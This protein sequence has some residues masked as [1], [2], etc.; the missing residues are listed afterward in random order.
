[1]VITAM[2]NTSEEKL[3]QTIDLI[4]DFH[5]KY[6]PGAVIGAYM[7]HL[8]QEKLQPLSGKLNAIAESTVC[9]ADAIQIM[10]GCTIGNKYLWLLNY[11][12]YALC[13]YDRDTKEGIRV[14]VDYSKIDPVKTP[15]L[16][17]F[18]DGTRTYESIDRPTQQQMVNQE[19]SP[20]N[21]PFLDGKKFGLT[22]QVKVLYQILLS[23]MF[24][25]N[26]IK[27]SSNRHVVNVSPR[28][29]IMKLLLR[30]SVK[31][32]IIKIG[33]LLVFG[34]SH[35]II[36]MQDPLVLSQFIIRQ[37]KNENKLIFLYVG[38]DVC[39]ESRSFL[40]EIV[41]DK[42]YYKFIK[43]NFIVSILDYDKNPSLAIRYS[44]PTIPGFLIIDSNGNTFFGTYSRKASSP[45]YFT[46]NHR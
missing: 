15:T 41:S 9:L 45:P 36:A 22:Y 18:F 16:K 44:L 40:S 23:V 34:T 46:I 24:V 26:I 42:E 4:C 39:L 3:L 20:S 27:V 2:E 7:V 35:P 25:T 19:F 5:G 8:A 29:S 33:L 31:Y 43:D 17:K 30:Y 38:S 21:V 11:G 6:A 32:W 37:A 10:T 13:L 28:V 14:W 12:R 1:M